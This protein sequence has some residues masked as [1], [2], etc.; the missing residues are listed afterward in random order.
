MAIGPGLGPRLKKCGL[1]PTGPIVAR[2]RPHFYVLWPCFKN[3]ASEPFFRSDN[4]LD[5]LLVFE[6]SNTLSHG[7]IV[8]LLMLC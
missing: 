4:L 5:F 7:T 6:A 2:F 8:V 1:R 3:A